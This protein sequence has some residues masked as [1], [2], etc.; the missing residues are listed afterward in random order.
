MRLD[1]LDF[2]RVQLELLFRELVA[3]EV[4]DSS[5]GVISRATDLVREALSIIRNFAEN[6]KNRHSGNRYQAP[7]SDTRQT[8]IQYTP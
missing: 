7:F 6:M 2:Q 1:L 3:V 8:S 4:F 5:G